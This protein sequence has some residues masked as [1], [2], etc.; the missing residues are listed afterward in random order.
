[1][2]DRNLNKRVRNTLFFLM[3]FV[4]IFD[5]VPKPMQ[6]NFIGGPV[7]GKLEFYPLM[8]A[9][10][11]SFY[12]Q[13]RYRNVFVDFKV[14]CKYAAIF[15]GMMMLATIV[16]LIDYP[17]YDLILNGPADQIEKLPKVMSFLQAHGIFVE[18]KHLMQVWLIVREIKGVLLEVFWCLGGAYLVYAWYKDEWSQA[19]RLAV[20]A[21]TCSCCVLL[22]YAIVEVLYLVGNET[23][24]EIL[25]FINPYIHPIVTSHGWWPPLLWKGQLR[26]V[27]PEP[28]HV[29]NY[30]A[31]GLPLI[32]YG[33]IQAD[34][35]RRAAL[36][37]TMVMAFLVFMTKAR[38]AYAMLAGML[39]LLVCLIFWGRQY[40]LL[41]KFAVLIVCVTIGFVGYVSF[42]KTTSLSRANQAQSVVQRTLEDNLV[43]LASNNKRSNGARYGLLKAHFRTGLQHPLLGVG[44]GLTGVYVADNF[45]PEEAANGEI[46]SWI[47]YQEERGP[48]AAG[49]SMPDAMNEFVSRFS[50]TGIL[51]LGTFLFPFAYVLLRLLKKWVIRK[52]LTAMMMMLAL[53]SSMMAGCNGSLNLMYA[54]WLLLGLSYAVAFGRERSMN[55]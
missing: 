55:E 10:I 7:G 53:I 22:V 26:L 35:N 2:E 18:Q 38:T 52:D 33:Y 43:S 4:L 21:V 44:K 27:F 37:L 16:G 46:S 47:R 1:M 42:V 6:M 8:A 54:V 25:S 45:T 41:K 28:S 5:S 19:L 11:Y 23:A 20:R 40:E 32:W 30:I 17:Y 50:S 48:M 49:Y 14:F 9:F 15:V 29:G 31:F 51:G 13:Y 24:K 12:C 34:T 3:V 36:P 39:L